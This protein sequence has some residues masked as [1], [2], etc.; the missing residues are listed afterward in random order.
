MKDI[1]FENYASKEQ[2]FIIPL[3]FPNINH[4]KPIIERI[5][6]GGDLWELRVDLLSP[7]AADMTSVNLPSPEYVKDQVQALQS[8]SDLP[9]L[10]T[11]RTK[12]QGGKFPDDAVYEAMELMLLAVTCGIQYIDVEIEWP[13]TLLDEIISK[14]KST[15]LVASYHS[16]TGDIRWTSQ[17]LQKRFKAANDFGGSSLLLV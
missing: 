12:S 11:I 8:M 9:I 16:W 17:E 6:Y 3:T 2:T 13:Q 15:K 1:I 5:S 7:A 4:A 10:F 14:K